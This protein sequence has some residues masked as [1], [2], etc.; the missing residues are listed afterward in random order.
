MARIT[1]KEYAQLAIDM[2]TSG[3]PDPVRVN[4]MYP[5][6]VMANGIHYA[7][8]ATAT[9]AFAVWVEV[10]VLGYSGVYF[11]RWVSGSWRSNVTAEQIKELAD[12]EDAC[13]PNNLRQQQKLERRR[14]LTSVL[15]YARPP[16][17][18]EGQVA[19]HERF[20]R[21]SADHEAWMR[22]CDVVEGW[23]ERYVKG[24]KK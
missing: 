21:H 15:M 19:N 9:E 3:S 1:P 7:S 23:A 24:A 18:P 4:D 8:C 13:P 17:V 14:R 11:M 5:Y 22:V 16:G 20:I 2:G 6:A 12:A 10:K